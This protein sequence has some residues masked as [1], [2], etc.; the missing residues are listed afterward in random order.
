MGRSSGRVGARDLAGR[1]KERKIFL[2]RIAQQEVLDG[3]GS[4]IDGFDAGNLALTIGL[5]GLLIHL[6]EDRRHQKP[7][8]HQGQAHQR[9]IRGGGLRSQRLAQKVKDHQQP[10]QRGHAHQN[11]RQQGDQREDQQNGPGR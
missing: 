5:N 3:L 10:H 2:A 1:G 4:A 6:I 7:G 11:G 8:H 9:R